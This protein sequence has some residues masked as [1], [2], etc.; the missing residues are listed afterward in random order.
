M[1]RASETYQE[2]RKVVLDKWLQGTITDLVDNYRRM[3]LR[4]SGKWE[5]TI[6]ATVVVEGENTRARIL[7]QH[8]SEYMQNGRRRN[9]VQTPDAI[10]RW[11]GW[12]GSTFLKK[13]VEDKGIAAN[14]FAVAQKIAR[15]GIRVPNRYNA[16]DVVAKV[17]NAQRIQQLAELVKPDTIEF[18]RSE[19]R[20]ILRDGN[21]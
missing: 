14:P 4:A 16:G 18:A 5:Q 19:I 12:A 6:H 1:S 3:G 10:R 7:A 21:K 2:R 8:Y 13:W 20:K 17:I 9:S 11:V 15:E